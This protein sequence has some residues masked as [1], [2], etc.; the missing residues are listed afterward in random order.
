M[1]DAMN[2]DT[3]ECIRPN[4]R[5]RCRF[6]FKTTDFGVALVGTTIVLTFYPPR[7]DTITRHGGPEVISSM[8]A[9]GWIER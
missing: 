8:N 9:E 6:D 3:K 7:P 4:K 5:K 1:F 2:A